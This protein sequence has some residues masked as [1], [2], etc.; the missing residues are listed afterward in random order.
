MVSTKNASSFAEHII[1]KLNR[2]IAKG[3]ASNEPK[4]WFIDYILP[5]EKI[6]S[7]NTICELRLIVSS[8]SKMYDQYQLYFG[9]SIGT[10]KYDKT[11]E[12]YWKILGQ[13]KKIK[14]INNCLPNKQPPEYTYC[15]YLWLSEKFKKLQT[16]IKKLRVSPQRNCLTVN[17]DSEKLLWDATKNFCKEIQLSSSSGIAPD[18]D[19]VT[20]FKECCVCADETTYKTQCKHPICIVCLSCLGKHKCPLCRS[21]IFEPDSS[22]DDDDDEDTDDDDEDTDNDDNEDADNEDAEEDADN[23]D[24]IPIIT[25][26]NSTTSITT[27]ITTRLS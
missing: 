14:K 8:K 9:I 12:I 16:L 1:N 22:D 11:D 7:V 19:I 24:I 5:I 13:D 27:S 6:D 25:T 26:D 18:N 10:S 21:T 2:K 4:T 17:Y 23:E 20:S 3:V 15:A